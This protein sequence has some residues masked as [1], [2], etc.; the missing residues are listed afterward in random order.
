MMALLGWNV[1]SVN[2]M[3]FY[4][5]YVVVFG[6]VGSQL[7]SIEHNGMTFVKKAKKECVKVIH[8]PLIVQ[9]YTE[10][11]LVLMVLTEVW[12]WPLFWVKGGENW[13]LYWRRL[14]LLK[15]L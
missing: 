2:K 1:E 14:S 7:I 5:K 11:C 4:S 15:H 9:E 10:L 8:H 12:N 6:S 3:L 13:S